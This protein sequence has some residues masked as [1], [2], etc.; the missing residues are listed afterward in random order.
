[1]PTDTKLKRSS[2]NLGSLL[3]VHEMAAID[4]V[5]D[6]ARRATLTQR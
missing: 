4:P 3:H 5:I 2:S 1:M 6:P